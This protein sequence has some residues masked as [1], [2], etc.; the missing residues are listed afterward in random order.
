MR[1]K[2]LLL[3]LFPFPLLTFA[4]TPNWL[5]AKSG[6]GCD[7]NMAYSVTSDGS[8]NIIVAGYFNTPTITFGS[9][10]LTSAGVYDIFL[11][12]YDASGNVTWAKSAG[13]TGA[14][15]AYTITTDANNAIL[16]AG[17]FSSSTITFGTTTLT[18]A[19]SQND[20]FVVKYDASGNVLWAKSAGGSGQDYV[21]SAVA[22]GGGNFLVA[23]YFMSGSITFGTTTL[24]S[25]GSADMFL[26]KYDTN[27]NV[28]WA[29]RAG[30]SSDEIGYSVAV[31]VNNNICV[32]G[33][34]SSTT[35][36]FGT[37]T[38]TN[39]S[40]LYDMFVA[41][42]DA[43]GNVSWAKCAGGAEDD[44]A[45][46]VT[47]DA[48]GN[49]YVA[50]KFASASILF[51]TTTLTNA[52]NLYDD[53]FLVKYSSTGNITWAVRAGGY[54]IDNATAIATDASGNVFIAGNYSS[55]TL[56][57]GSS[58]LTNSGYSDVFVAKYDVSG[59]ALWG[60]SANGD[61]YDKIYSLA[62]DASGNLIVAGYFQSS[63]FSF[64]SI[65]L[66]HAAYG[67]GNSNLY[68]AKLSGST[69]IENIES[70]TV[71]SIYPNPVVSDLN[72]EISDFRNHRYYF[73]IY[74]ATG[75]RV[76]G[77]EIFQ[78]Q[79]IL[80]LS[81]LASGIYQLVVMDG[82]GNRKEMK[83]VRSEQ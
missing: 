15:E 55:S 61:D 27:G 31:D 40:S 19:S 38:L 72:I 60:K 70:G 76:L 13:G 17:R 57:F 59:N 18:N 74:S 78:K 26:V 80:D 66:T 4:Q 71:F 30:G 50:G 1:A 62:C 75:Q 43:S 73:E 63:T 28:T 48:S 49:V 69:G 64:G 54:S 21:C 51:G 65:N 22:D 29:K 34:F 25:A 82:K 35:V 9:T 81:K 7:E 42:Y 6:S 83:F 47:T 39:A 44:A 36:S 32:A 23:G 56:S 24:T 16:V 53:I 20:V 11:V 14:D 67:S 33:V 68:V 52:L 79:T 58:T 12:K 3:A 41:K 5:W 45:G 2:I 46:A 10:T 37:T 77:A 8:G